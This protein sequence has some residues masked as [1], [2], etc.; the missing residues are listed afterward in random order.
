VQIVD[1]GLV[2]EP[3]VALIARPA[4]VVLAA[5]L[6]AIEDRFVLALVIGTA[7]CE[8]ILGPDDEGRPFAAGGGEGFR[9]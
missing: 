1:A 9:A 8:G 3:H 5:V 6:P 7:Q 4:P 2:D